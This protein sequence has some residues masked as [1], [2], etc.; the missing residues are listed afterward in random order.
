M[1]RIKVN[2]M[3]AMKKRKKI[4]SSH[5]Y[6]LLNDLIVEARKLFLL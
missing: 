1:M 3:R 6:N 4:I 2:R 5:E